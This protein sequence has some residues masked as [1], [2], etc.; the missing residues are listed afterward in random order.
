VPNLSG[1]MGVFEP[2]TQT[3]RKILG[4]TNYYR[5]PIYQRPYSWG[6]EEIERLWDDI[7]SAFNDRDE[8]YFLGPVILAR[9]KDRYLEVVDGQQRITTLTI[10]FCI[11]RDFHLK[12]LK[13]QVLKNQV[14]NTIRSMVDNRYRLRLVTQANYQN[15][16]EQEIL[17]KVV[18]PQG[19]LTKSEKRKLK[20]KFKNA[21]WILKKRLDELH[22]RSGVN[23]IKSLIGYILQNV[24]LVTITCS[25]RV[26]AIKLFQVINTTGLDLSL[27]DLVKS[28]LISRLDSKKHDQ[29]IS[30]W[31]EIEYIAESNGESVSDLLTYYTYY[32][33][34]SKPKRSLDEELERKFKKKNSNTVVHDFKVFADHYDTILNVK[35][36]MIY[37]L[38]NLP[39]RVFWK[40][41][42]TTAKMEGLS[43]FKQLCKKLRNLYYSYWIAGYTTAKTRNFSFKLIRLIKEGKPLSE[44][45]KEIDES[46]EEDYV[47]EYAKDNLGG[48]C[49][50]ETW[51][52]P[53][54]I[55]IEYGQTDDLVFIEYSRHLH[56]DHILPGEW[57]KKRYWKRRWTDEEADELLHTLGNLTL[58]SGKKNIQASNDDFPKKK[59]IY[60][61]RGFDGKTS[62]QISQ[63]ILRNA[64]WTAKEVEKRQ[65]WLI[66]QT[67]NIL[68]LK[69]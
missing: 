62:F 32:L 13:D 67:K 23:K 11:L 25:N 45:T 3:V 39:D 50:G 35:A 26:S 16:F 1:A 54:L 43:R 36:K 55:L 58:L 46:L 40:T 49:Y 44:I 21:A 53:L 20:N 65:R 9:R 66:K 37:S 28:S 57:E 34:A 5:I 19:A 61:G 69:L 6:D 56:V 48:D 17:K 7:S 41:I 10:L 24:V 27:A 12:N 63:R 68:G 60:K 4:G 29:F 52:K 33:L 8:Y 31:R 38:R 14:S 30:T 47:S 51:L 15:K 18:L 64:E 59:K 22:H 42:L 2:H